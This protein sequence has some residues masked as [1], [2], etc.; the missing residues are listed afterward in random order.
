MAN[1]KKSSSPPGVEEAAGKL[2]L[3][4]GKLEKALDT[5]GVSKSDLATDELEKEVEKLKKAN[6][7]LRTLLGISIII[8]ANLG[9]FNINSHWVAIVGLLFFEILGILIY[10]KSI[11]DPI[12]SDTWKEV[13]GI[14]K[15]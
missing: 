2:N 8:T 7:T 14:F 5:A 3:D 10:S 15:K 13:Q 6:R 9:L 11:G 12:L 4:I 1:N